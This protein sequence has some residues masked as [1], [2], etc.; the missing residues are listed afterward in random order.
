MQFWD[1]RFSDDRE[2]GHLPEV[3][4]PAILAR[5]LCYKWHHSG[6]TVNMHGKQFFYYNFSSVCDGVG[7]SRQENELMGL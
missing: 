2:C 6:K 5:M 3:E 4:H 1:G 7:E